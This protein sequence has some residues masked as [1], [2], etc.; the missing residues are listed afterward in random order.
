MDV[1]SKQR[2]S[3]KRLR[4]CTSLHLCWWVSEPPASVEDR[5][6]HKGL[7][8]EW[9]RLGELSQGESVLALNTE[10]LGYSGCILILLLSPKL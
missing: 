3:R 10:L 5:Q 9:P 6:E 7:E 8:L 4:V 1:N 2:E